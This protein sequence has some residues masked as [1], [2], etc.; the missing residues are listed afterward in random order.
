MIDIRAKV[1]QLL[2]LVGL[3]ALVEELFVLCE[4]REQ[5]AIR[6]GG[7]PNGWQRAKSLLWT[8]NHGED[9]R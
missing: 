3:R 9:R 4:E 8:I 1:R 6:D 5:E 2:K 7:D